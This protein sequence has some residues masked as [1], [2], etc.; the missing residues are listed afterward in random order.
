M[1]GVM[2]EE[3]G[4]PGQRSEAAF[5]RHAAVE[6]LSG[7]PVDRARVQH[8]LAKAV[9]LMEDAQ[10]ALA[11][12]GGGATG[13]ANGAAVTAALGSLPDDDT[14]WDAVETARDEVARS[15]QLGE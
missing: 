12:S 6:A 10:R 1:G 15:W 2:S 3:T 4:R 7:R 14:Y 11:R 8:D 9:E 5:I 13:T